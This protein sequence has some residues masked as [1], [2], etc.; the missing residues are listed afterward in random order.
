M[1]KSSASPAEA[2]D[3][4]STKSEE[5]D[6]SITNNQTAGVDEGGIVKLRGNHLV[7]LRRGR[8]FTVNIGGSAL[9]PISAIDAFP[10]GAR[11]G[12]T[13]Y[14]EMLISGNT[15]AVIGYSYA[16][17]GTE[18][19]LFN[20]DREGNLEYQSTYHLRS[21]D[22]YSSRN[23]A[24]RLVDGKLVFYT[25]QYLAINRNN[26]TSNFPA[27]RRWRKGVKSSEFE[28]IVSARRVYKPVRDLP[29]N[30][31]L[32]L[33]TVTTCA[34]DGG[35]LNCEGTSILG[36]SGRIFYV[37]AQSVYVWT[38]S[39]YGR[40]RTE[41]SRS[42]LYQLPLSGAAPKAIRVSGAPV[43]QFSFL[44]SS[45]EHLNV[46]VRSFGRGEAMWGS[47]T[48]GGS[49]AL[50]RIP[51][52]LF[53]D[54]SETAGTA[55]YTELASPK[56]YTFQN[57]YVG[58]Y[59]LYGSGGGW[60][61]N[62]KRFGGEL[63]AVNWK[64]GLQTNVPLEHDVSRIERLGKN[65]VIVG[66]RGSDLH[67][68]PIDL[69][70]GVTARKGYVR[71]NASQ[72]ELRSHGFFYRRTGSDTGILGLPIAE[73]NRP[74]YKHL[75]NGSASVLYLK[76]NSLDF[77][78][79]GTLKSTSA[80]Q[81]DDNCKASCVDWYGNARPLFIRGRVFAL[82]GYELVEGSVSRGTIRERRRVD[83]TPIRNK[84]GN[85]LD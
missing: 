24:S 15:I 32:A 49:T 74:G 25:P 50:L 63:F 41:K 38:T 13:W 10:P 45:D 5:S 81:P 35:E 33:H 2:A 30:S 43:D 73:A 26:P 71:R 18:V 58:D 65:A 54:G 16:R 82:L 68:S 51:T 22:Y 44:E 66:T 40:N 57:R 78:E 1:D 17:G 28:K 56:G 4:E 60:G 3:N 39:G 27:I 46:L 75:R 31:S 6:E 12:G 20:I 37:S 79:L 23:Y 42:V 7:V 19:G 29:R 83:F 52:Y 64:T 11:P 21:N 47:E 80:K 67:F 84:Y 69:N 85:L 77:K 48:T 34:I 61:R 55:L 72:G 70:N 14:D 76:N 8:L 53:S 62:S 59:L 36:P 9:K